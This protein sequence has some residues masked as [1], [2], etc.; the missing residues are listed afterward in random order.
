MIR[1]VHRRGVEPDPLHGL[2][3]TTVNGRPA[4]VEYEPDPDLRDTEQ[5]PLLEEG[6]VEAFLE[7][8]VLPYAPDAWFDPASVKVGYEI[9]FNRYFYRPAP[10][11]TLEE[12]RAEIL[13]VRKE[14]E[15]LLDEILG[16]I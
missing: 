16:E 6:G 4:V 13:A 3:E 14:S 10:M 7:R 9:S 8:E 1:K 12:I 2:F 5:V 15:G 11:R